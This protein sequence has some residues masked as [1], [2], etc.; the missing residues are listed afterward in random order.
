MASGLS[1][2]H[3]NLPNFVLLWSGEF[4]WL[5]G[6]R[7]VLEWEEGAAAVGGAGGFKKAVPEVSYPHGC[8]PCVFC[9][10]PVTPKDTF[11]LW[12]LQRRGLP[13]ACPMLSLHQAHLGEMA[14]PGQPLLRVMDQT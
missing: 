12:P 8:Q 2:E 10:W 11:C 14:G 3:T 9:C 6:Q 4:G 5:L 13:Q 7:R 1:V